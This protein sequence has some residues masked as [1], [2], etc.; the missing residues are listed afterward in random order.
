MLDWLLT[1]LEVDATVFHRGQYCGAFRASTSGHGRATFHVVLRGTCFLHR[2]DQPPVALRDGDVV[3][4]L[5]DLVHTLS[6]APSHTFAQA[7]PLRE[8]RMV[9]I[10][11]W[12]EPAVGLVCGFFDFKAGLSELIASA[13]PDVLLVQHDDPDTENIRRV[14]ALIVDEGLSDGPASSLLIARLASV[15]VPYVLRHLAAREGLALGLLQA[16]H[17]PELADVVEQIVA[18]PERDWSLASMA[19]LAG[20]SRATF[21]KRWTEVTRS[22]PMR[23][24]LAVRIQLATRHLLRGDSIEAVAERVGYHS[25]AA[26]ARAFQRVTGEQPGAYRR[27]RTAPSLQIP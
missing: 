15:L 18:A 22:S 9:P 13:L 10:E 11:P 17:H 3:F 20:T 12:C 6:P 27:S 19:R 5:R 7:E 8:G 16:V 23:F 2:P 14:V 1:S 21:V 26:F 25:T 24:L 4:L